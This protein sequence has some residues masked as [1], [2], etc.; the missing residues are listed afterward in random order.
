MR[1]LLQWGRGA[2]AAEGTVLGAQPANESAA[3]MGAAALQ[4]RKTERQSWK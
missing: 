2:S 3:S 1:D 4:P